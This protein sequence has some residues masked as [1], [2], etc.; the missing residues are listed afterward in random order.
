VKHT[1][2][3]TCAAASVLPLAIY[4]LTRSATWALDSIYTIDCAET[5]LAASTLGIDHPPGHPLYLILAH[6]FSL[7]PLARPDE[8]VI[9][10]SVFTMSAAAGLFAL[11][12]KC[13]TGDTCAAL[14]TNWSFAFGLV[15]WFHAT[16]A[17]VYGIQLACV[18][19]FY[20]LASGWLQGRRLSLYYGQ[21]FALGLTATTNVLLA[22]LLLPGFFYLTW[23]SGL[24]SRWRI[25]LV[26]LASL[27][28]GAT[29]LLYIPIRL[30]GDGFISD[31][32][33]LNGYE[34][35]S[36]R[37]YLSAEEFTAT[38]I[39]ATPFSQYPALFVTYISTFAEHHSPIVA[40]LTGIGIFGVFRE[41]ANQEHPTS[42]RAKLM[43]APGPHP[44]LFEHSVLIGFLAT[45]LPVLPYQ[46]ADRQ[47]FYMPS[48]AHLALLAGYGVWKIS[49]AVRGATF[50]DP[51]KR[52][53]IVAFPAIIAIFLIV[54]HYHTIASITENETIYAEREKRFLSLPRGAIVTR[55]DDG[56]ATRWN[57]WQIVRNLRPDARIERL[58][59]LAPR[60]QLTTDGGQT[61]G[62]P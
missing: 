62:L 4:L 44:A 14:A 46:V 61:M 36:L 15:V 28:V 53:I 11:P 56:R 49:N 5:V 27:V 7:L 40:V 38:K 32:V 39:T 18:A 43:T 48:F 41:H 19:A 60:N 21:C 10:S 6:M 12:I 20:A 59:K 45:L 55:T 2:L 9:L 37:W 31:F 29:P 25:L 47:V 54:L 16:I 8:G 42:W 33:Y 24:F 50:P 51:F 17:E 34:V 35:G 52:W 1:G 26:G 30:G 13:R 57:Y 22:V 23:R 3:T 58:G